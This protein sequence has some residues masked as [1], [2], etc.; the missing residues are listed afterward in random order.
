MLNSA[1][2]ITNSGLDFDVI[3]EREHYWENDNDNMEPDEYFE[4]E[5]DE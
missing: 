2:K 1:V 3:P 5:Y 4:D